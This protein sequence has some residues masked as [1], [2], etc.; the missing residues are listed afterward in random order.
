MVDI[1]IAASLAR[2]TKNQRNFQYDGNSLDDVLS[3]LCKKH[4]ELSKF[5]YKEPTTLHPFVNIYIDDKNARD[6]QGLKTKV[7]AQNIVRILPGIAGG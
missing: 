3:C 2:F 4:L 5:I 7:H 1:V 6:L